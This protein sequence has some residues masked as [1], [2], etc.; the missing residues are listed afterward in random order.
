MAEKSGWRRA[1]HKQP[2]HLAAIKNP[3]KDA[4]VVPGAL[5]KY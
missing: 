3:E 4:R 5:S 2:L 1:R